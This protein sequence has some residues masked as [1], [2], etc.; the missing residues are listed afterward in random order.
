[1]DKEEIWRDIAGYEGLYQVSDMGRV[2]S[3]ERIVIRKN[4]SKLPVK[5]RIL[6]PRPDGRGYLQIAFYNG[7]GKIKNFKVHHFVFHL[8]YHHYLFQTLL[9]LFYFFDIG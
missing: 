1:M 4:G 3:L 8:H 9:Y 7:S 5:E 2:K 6:K